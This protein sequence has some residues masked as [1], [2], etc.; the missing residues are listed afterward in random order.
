MVP[1]GISVETLGKQFA[2]AGIKNHT[3]TPELTVSEARLDVASNASM[4]AFAEAYVTKLAPAGLDHKHLM[5]I[6]HEVTA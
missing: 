3:L 5:S 6:F 2:T 4:T 1:A